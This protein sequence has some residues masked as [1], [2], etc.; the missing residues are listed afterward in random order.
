[1]QNNNNN[2]G[3]TQSGYTTT[4]AQSPAYLTVLVPDANAEIW[5]GNSATAAKGIQ[6][7]FQSPALEPGQ[8]YIYTVKAKWMDNGKPV[9]QSRE[10]KVRAG[11]LSTV[12]F[13]EAQRE[14]IPAQEKNK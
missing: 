14:N 10:V 7:Q 6:R 12:N 8:D 3:I 4:A 2:N 5:L 11:Q 9:E 1:M 13:Y